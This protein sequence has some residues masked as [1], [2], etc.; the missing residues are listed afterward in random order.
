LVVDRPS[1]KTEAVLRALGYDGI[2]FTAVAASACWMVNLRA[3]CLQVA[4]G[5]MACGV[6]L[7][8]YAA[9]AMVLANKI[10]GVRAVQATRIESVLGGIRHIGANV[11]VAEHRLSTFHELRAMTRSFICDRMVSGAAADIVAF[12]RQLEGK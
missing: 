5:S 11:L 10:V 1:E 12:I 2:R 4:G 8:P 6:A 9:N 7:L 3:M